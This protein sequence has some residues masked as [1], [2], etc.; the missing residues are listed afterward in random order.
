MEK[1]SPE[2]PEEG[3]Q[4]ENNKDAIE[5]TANFEGN[6]TLVLI[7]RLK[8]PV[9]SEQI[10]DIHYRQE[11]ESY[12]HYHNENWQP[13]L[14][15][16][17]TGEEPN[18][19]LKGEKSGEVISVEDLK[20]VLKNLQ[21]PDKERLEAELGENIERIE[22]S[23]EINYDNKIPDAD[24]ISVTWEVPWTQK[25]PTVKIMSITEAHEK[26]HHVRNYHSSTEELREG[27]DISEVDFSEKTYQA[28][29]RVRNN[30]DEG[31][32]DSDYHPSK[33]EALEAYI[34]DYLFTGDE[35]AERMSQ[36]K[37]YF[38][39]RSDEKFTREHLQYAKD[40]YVEDT[41]CDN[42]MTEF[43]QA[44]TE[45]TEDRFIDLINSY[46]I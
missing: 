6:E 39:F 31:Y 32:E 46:G 22:K 2:K 16:G 19:L 18:K 25:R 40:H 8:H 42:G 24:S 33:E 29:Q 45:E 14:P 21:N 41:E 28:L 30:P 27:F 12:N 9:I 36:L 38:G 10:V 37:N 44:V 15:D 4:Q 5:K 17:W 11:A 1:F 13:Y 7:E 43:L 34:Q 23:T 35:I 20:T 3:I 26:G